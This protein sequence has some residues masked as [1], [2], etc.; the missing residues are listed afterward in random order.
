MNEYLFLCQ[1]N[2]GNK[3]YYYSK[4]MSDDSMICTNYSYSEHS[5]K[6]TSTV[7]KILCKSRD[8]EEGIYSCFENI[9][10]VRVKN[11]KK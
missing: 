2:C 3:V 5:N 11:L 8:I 6:I 7:G 1:N 10:Y 4:C 9:F